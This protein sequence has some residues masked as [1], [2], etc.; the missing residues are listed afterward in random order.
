MA[1]R[2]IVGV[3]AP[4]EIRHRDQVADEAQA[5]A[6]NP[7][8]PAADHKALMAMHALGYDMSQARVIYSWT[9]KVA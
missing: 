8:G 2:M 7:Q 3:T 1:H 9:P 4:L 6:A 5:L